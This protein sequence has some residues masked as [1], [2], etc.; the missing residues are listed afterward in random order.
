MRRIVRVW[1]LQKSRDVISDFWLVVLPDVTR[2]LLC[3][4]DFGHSGTSP[5]PTWENIYCI[6]D[7]EGR[8]HVGNR[9]LYETVH[10]T[11]HHLAGGGASSSLHARHLMNRRPQPPVKPSAPKPFG[12][13]YFHLRQTR[14]PQHMI[15]TTRPTRHRHSVLTPATP[16][17]FES[18]VRTCLHR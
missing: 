10:A 16:R 8:T 3:S 7:S 18:R 4:H 1:R 6:H 14:T 17:P 15:C 13:P 5:A 9:F 2:W 12:K 11:S